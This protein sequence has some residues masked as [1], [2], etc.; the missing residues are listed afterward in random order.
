MRITV[1]LD[2]PETYFLKE[3]LRFIDLEFIFVEFC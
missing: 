2:K 3:L 1:I